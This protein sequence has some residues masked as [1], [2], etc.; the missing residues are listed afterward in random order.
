MDRLHK[1]LEKEQAVM[2]LETI[3]DMS[4]LHR[5]TFLQLVIVYRRLKL[6]RSL[7]VLNWLVNGVIH[8]LCSY[9]IVLMW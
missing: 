4:L 2:L 9:L 6:E 1:I 5:G 8:L 3:K 7:M